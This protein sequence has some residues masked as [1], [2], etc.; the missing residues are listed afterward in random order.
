MPDQNGEKKSSGGAAVNRITIIGNIGAPPEWKH[1]EGQTA[2]C[3][4]TVGVSRGL[5]KND[6]L[7]TLW[8]RVTLWG[9]LAEIAM[10]YGLKSQQV[11]VEGR[12]TL[13]EW[14]D[15]DG[16]IRYTLEIAG[17]EFQ[18][19]GDP[20]HALLKEVEC[21]D[22]QADNVTRSRTSRS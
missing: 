6:K 18:M 3:V 17:S 9:R 16:R 10:Q 11:Y 7:D 1:K 14:V 22:A 2:Y 4:F 19:T 20:T 12:M 13:S 5:R 8:Y 15:N 21:L